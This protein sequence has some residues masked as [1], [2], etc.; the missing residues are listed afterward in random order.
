[1]AKKENF[2]FETENK[3]KVDFSFFKDLTQK[4]KETILMIAIAVVAVIVIVVIGVII[5]MGGN[6]GGNGGNGSNGIFGNSGNNGSNGNGD[7][8]NNE[9]EYPVVK[10]YISG[11]PMTRTYSV[12]SSPDYSGLQIAID[13]GAGGTKYVAY[14]D[15]PSDVKITGFDSTAAIDKQVITVEYQGFTDTFTVKIENLQRDPVL[16]SIEIGTLPKTE[17]TVGKPISFK[18]GTIICTYD[19]GSVKEIGIKIEYV[20][21]LP[22]NNI[23]GEYTIRV[24]YGEKGVYKET[25]YNIIIK[26]AE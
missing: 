20:Q 21:E 3:F 4:Q 8:Q 23:P 22:D 9:N 14:E 11:I 25:S 1:M 7:S 24:V 2:D 19:D 5:L 16:V 18:N 26:D 12:G 10:M 6:N 17:F 15:F 13:R